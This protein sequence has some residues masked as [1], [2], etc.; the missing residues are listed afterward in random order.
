M[1]CTLEEPP[2]PMARE[3][4]V[5][6]GLLIVEASRSQTHTHTTFRQDSSGRV[7]S[8][9]QRPLPDNTQH[10]QDISTP[11]A[12]FEP[13]IPASERPQSHVS[14]RAATGIG[15]GRVLL[16]VKCGQHN[17][18][19]QSAG[20]RFVLCFYK[21]ALYSFVVYTCSFISLCNFVLFV[22]ALIFCIF[23]HFAI[24]FMLFMG[25]GGPIAVVGNLNR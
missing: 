16:Q 8:P 5:D 14:D 3:P 10:S 20:I 18:V 23:G 24:I 4:P 6:Q 17:Q 21:P 9:L 7:I 22:Y 1:F 12:G 19:S 15:T 2:L 25:S 11:P 13:A